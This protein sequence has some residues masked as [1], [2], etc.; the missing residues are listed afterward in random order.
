MV[1]I[2][3]SLSSKFIDIRCQKFVFQPSEALHCILRDVKENNEI[4]IVT[5]SSVSFSHGIVEKQNIILFLKNCSL[6]ISS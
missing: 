5:P 6:L 3:F 4:F 2:S 1:V